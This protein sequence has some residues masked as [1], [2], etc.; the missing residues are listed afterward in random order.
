MLWALRVCV[1]ATFSGAAHGVAGSNYA[2]RQGTTMVNEHSVLVNRLSI[3]FKGC[4]ML[5]LC[6][7]MGEAADQINVR[8]QQGEPT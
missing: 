6:L 3:G 2:E 5:L 4:L 1:I 8:V 7:G